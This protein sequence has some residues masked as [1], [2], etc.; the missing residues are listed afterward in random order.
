V[1]TIWRKVSRFKTTLVK[2]VAGLFLTR[3]GQRILKTQ[4][5]LKIKERFQVMLKLFKY[6]R[7]K[8]STLLG[9][10]N[11]KYFQKSRDF[12]G[13]LSEGFT[14]HGSFSKRAVQSL[15]NQYCPL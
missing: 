15:V 12:L 10:K 9:W 5:V 6:S 11:I 1:S 14:F 7:V 4:Q 13:A 3:L 8:S 2:P